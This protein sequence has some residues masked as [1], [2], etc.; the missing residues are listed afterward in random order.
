M[1]RAS[2]ILWVALAL[3]GV[4]PVLE[5]FQLHPHVEF[6]HYR[7]VWAGVRN[8]GSNFI[9]S[10]TWIMSTKTTITKLGPVWVVNGSVE[11]AQVILNSFVGKR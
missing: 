6:G 2:N 8:M 5:M 9:S 4:V 7:I 1:K 10:E 3:F 11:A